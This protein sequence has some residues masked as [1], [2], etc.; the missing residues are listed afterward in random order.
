MYIATVIKKNNQ[1]R[2]V[3]FA[4]IMIALIKIYHIR[5]CN[6]LTTV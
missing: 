5:M 2:N 6:N 3:C 1:Y 4:S